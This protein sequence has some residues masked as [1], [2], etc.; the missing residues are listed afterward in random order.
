MKPQ[1]SLNSSLGY[2]IIELMIAMTIGLVISMAIGALYVGNKQ[3]YSAQDEASRM[4]ESA[5][6][7]LDILGYHIRQAGYVDYV[8]FA[9]AGNTPR[10]T[11]LVNPG[12]ASWLTKTGT[13]D[14]DK[15][16]A[17]A[18]LFDNGVVGFKYNGIQ[19]IKGC[20]RPFSNLTSVNL[21]WTC[22]G[23]SKD[24]NAVIVAYQAR[25]T[26]AA[27]G[28]TVRTTSMS[29]IDTL[30]TFNAA[31]GQGGD[32]GARDVAGASANPSGPLAI[33]M[34]YIDKKSNRLMCV[35]SGNPNAPRPIAEGVE[36]M[37]LLYGISPATGGTTYAGRYVK[38]TDVTDWSRVLAVRAC[39]QVASPNTGS[40]RSAEGTSFTDCSGATVSQPDSKIRRLYRATFTLRNAI[41]T[42]PG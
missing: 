27:D 13:A 25:P 2:S 4:E 6:A 32:C 34:F 1:Y 10:Y 18:R 40:A 30:G 26:E 14:A 21:P 22:P 38:A 31:T 3:T 19:A 12:N 16:D 36:D 29:Y 20:D 8:D 33:N 11:Q 28:V 7:A 23:G 24:A 41:S 37:Q 15:K 17:I 9:N 42:V 5:K 35:G 39:L